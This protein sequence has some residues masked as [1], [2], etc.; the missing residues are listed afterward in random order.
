MG[1]GA[2]VLGRAYAGP[3]ESVD[4]GRHE[5]YA[6]AVLGDRQ[7]ARQLERPLACFAAVY[8]LWPM[9]NQLFRDPELQLDLLR[10]LHG[11]QEFEFSRPV[12]FGELLQPSARISR[13]DERRGSTFVELSCTARDQ[14]GQAVVASRSLFV[15]RG[16]P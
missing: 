1:T 5:S 14:G 10:L 7:A 11:E 4:R 12:E 6:A 9:V 15:I 8:L 2:S 16:G 3:A 13:F